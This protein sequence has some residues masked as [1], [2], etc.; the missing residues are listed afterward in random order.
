[1]LPMRDGVKLSVYLYFPD[2]EGPWPVLYEQRY[3]D[4]TVAGS[5]RNYEMLASKGY[6]V[7]AQNFRGAQKS[8]GVYT[9]YRALSWG[10]QQDGYDT[11]EWLAKQKWSTGKIGTFG[12]SQAGY[13]QNFLAVTR[14][15]HLVAQYMTD[16]GQSLFHLGYRRG[17]TTR[18]MAFQEA[19]DP[20][21]AINLNRAI[22]SHAVY[23]DYWH[24]EDVTR[25]WSK[26][27]VPCFTLGSWYD[28]MNVGSVESYVAR[29]HQGGPRS[30]GK[31][32]LI[33]G[34]WLH[35]SSYRHTGPV[36]DLV[37][38]PNSAFPV[39][40]HMV[41]WFD[42]YL[43][44]VDNGVEREPN[45]RYYVMGA[46]GEGENGAPG[47]VW[48]EA[49]DWPVPARDTTY[50]F[51]GATSGTAGILAAKK[52]SG[53]AAVTYNSDPAKPAPIAGRAFPGA[54]DAREFD[55]HPDVRTFTTEPLAAPV[56]WTGKVR[57]ELFVS[58]T[59]PDSDFIVRVTDVYPDGRS[60]LIID[61]IRRARFRDSWEKE[62]F[63]KPGEVYKV[64]FDVGY[65]SQVFNKGHRI[66][67]S[68]GST[69][70]P[71]Y[72]PNPQTGEPFDYDAPVKAQV[73]TQ[74]L[75]LKGAQASRIIAPVRK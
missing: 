34:P 26:M 3:S 14:P 68:V 64:S 49:A 48:R 32:K 44:G 33:I 18:R 11:V 60:I 1:M 56:E 35:G 5:R 72:D 28:F 20:K 36:G 61:G 58:S 38:P 51:H 41:R 74:T 10:E 73:A 63:M 70:S 43:K 46:V 6:V 8:E 2:G 57:A 29:Q 75:H 52:P 47:N 13:A 40:E 69:G 17:G 22:W 16:T 23:S 67:I 59:A 4:V 7:A 62:T 25:E 9:G 39:W 31:Q 54:K 50:F 37:Y 19:R 42:H 30:K 12:G 21:D 71:F 15:P 24:I 55:N 66:R 27:D 65:L 53:P 45:V